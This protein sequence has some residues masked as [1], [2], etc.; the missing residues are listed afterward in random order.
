MSAGVTGVIL[1]LVALVSAGVTD[2]I[3]PLVSYIC[4]SDPVDPIQ[5]NV[6]LPIHCHQATVPRQVLL[7]AQ[8][9]AQHHAGE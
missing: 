7:S 8:K 3:V 4:C 5:F 9:S 2:I 6:F 1:G